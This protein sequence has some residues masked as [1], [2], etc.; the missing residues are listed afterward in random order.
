VKA[1]MWRYFK[2]TSRTKRWCSE[3]RSVNEWGTKKY[4]ID[5]LFQV[6]FLGIVK[7][8]KNRTP[9]IIVDP[10]DLLFPS[11]NV[12]LRVNQVTDPTINVLDY[13]TF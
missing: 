12:N 13:I 9:Y 3:A 10:S 4:F 1:G 11:V 6:F 2:Q 8:S 5:F 7:A